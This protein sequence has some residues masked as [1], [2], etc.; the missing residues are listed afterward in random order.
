MFNAVICKDNVTRHEIDRYIDKGSFGGT[1][2]KLTKTKGLEVFPRP[3]YVWTKLSKLPLHLQD[4][5][6]LLLRSN[7][8]LLQGKAKIMGQPI[9]EEQLK[10]K[11]GKE[12]LMREAERSPHY[13]WKDLGALLQEI[14]P[15]L[16]Q[17]LSSD[18][19]QEQQSESKS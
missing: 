6:S 2:S 1:F 16:Q 4:C 13:S 8:W 15:D 3:E 17:T 10:S 18:D 11:K 7:M 14:D 19:L 5:D 12:F 9:S